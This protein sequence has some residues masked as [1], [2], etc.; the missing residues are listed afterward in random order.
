MR[1]LL[2]AVLLFFSTNLLAQ[3]QPQLI[4]RKPIKDTIALKLDSSKTQVREFDNQTIQEY[5]ADKE[6][7]YGDE[8]PKGLNWWQRFWRNFWSWLDRLFGE[9]NPTNTKPTIWPLVLKYT[10]I[11]ICIGLIV[12]A[13]FK[14]TGVD[15]KFLTGKSKAVDVPYDESLENIHEI[16]FDDEIENTLR[17][18]N[19][20]LAVRL[21][22][23]QTLKHLS[24][25]GVID[26]LPNKTNLAYV[27][28]V[29][30]EAGFDDFANLTNQFEY[31]WYGDFNIDKVTFGEI[32]QSFQQFNAAVK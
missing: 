28:E 32:Q 3:Q 18:G 22:Y 8:E 15:L 23:L 29:Q 13:I 31:I 12:F 30:K 1:I 9:R 25:K 14:L 11:V 20:R 21:L 2:L 27:K 19:Y 17:N 6:F 16:S 5:K 7:Q 24:D 10:T 4:V 26:W